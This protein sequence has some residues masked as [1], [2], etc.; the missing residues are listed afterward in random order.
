MN[1]IKEFIM[2]FWQGRVA[3]MSWDAYL[4]RGAANN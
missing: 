3:I 1:D 2:K 4:I